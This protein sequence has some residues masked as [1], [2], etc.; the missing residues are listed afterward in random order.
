MKAHDGRTKAAIYG[1]VFRE[2]K[3]ITRNEKFFAVFLQEKNFL[4]IFAV[5][6]GKEK[7]YKAREGRIS[8]AVEHFTRN[9]GV[10]SSN[11]GFGSKLRKRRRRRNER[12]NRFKVA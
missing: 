5:P 2:D 12:E 7:G 6:K 9:E 8:S 1:L 11:L 10:P 3:K 4:Q